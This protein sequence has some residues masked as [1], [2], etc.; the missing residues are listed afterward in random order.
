MQNHKRILKMKEE[1]KL[2]KQKLKQERGITL[3]ALVVT[4]I[5]LIILATIT[6]TIVVGENGLINR[7]QQAKTLQENAKDKEELDMILLGYNL[8][9]QTKKAKNEGEQTLKTYLEGEEG[10]TA[11]KE[12]GDNLIVTFKGQQYTVNKTT[13]A[14]GAYQTQGLNATDEAKV[15]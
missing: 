8:S 1:N 15:L 12:K 5:V 11:V 13:L 10:V 9:N 6:I 7:A 14:S 4:V 3:V 2:K